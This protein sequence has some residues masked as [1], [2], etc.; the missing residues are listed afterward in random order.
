MLVLA[1]TAPS[2]PNTLHN[3]EYHPV[4]WEE[5][6]YRFNFAKASAMAELAGACPRGGLP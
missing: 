6:G 5:L 2:Y 3:V 1:F 4:V